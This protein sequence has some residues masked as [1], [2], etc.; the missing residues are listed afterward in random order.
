VE[1]RERNAEI[2]RV[3]VQERGKVTQEHIS[4]GWSNSTV[5][6]SKLQELSQKEEGRRSQLM[7]DWYRGLS[8]A[9]KSAFNKH[10]LCIASTVLQSSFPSTF[11]DYLR[12][13]L[14]RL[15]LEHAAISRRFA[16]ARQ[17]TEKSGTDHA[18][19]HTVLESLLGGL[20][21]VEKEAKSRLLGRWFRELTEE[22][23]A[24]F[25]EKRQDHS[26][27][28]QGRATREEQRH[29]GKGGNGGPVIEN[30]NDRRDRFIYV[31][32]KKGKTRAW[33]KNRLAE[34]RTWEPLESEQGI[35][36]AA[37]RYAQRHD[38]PWPIKRT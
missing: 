13:P 35:S 1:G 30:P 22:Q 33:I 19:N 10:C 4:R 31:K 28:Q 17:Q 3:F 16:T 5:L 25:D 21:L 26:G 6:D 36:A 20:A 9:N 24:E 15:A 32:L 11:P 37:R 14:A 29:A 7:E 27:A 18:L 34:R 23:A 38:L 2:T 8:D 12:A